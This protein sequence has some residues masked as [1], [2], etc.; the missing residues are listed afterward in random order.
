[1][2]KLFRKFICF[3]LVAVLVLPAAVFAEEP[4]VAENVQTGVTYPDVQSALNGAA[5]G[6]TVRLLADTQAE[7]VYVGSGKIL[8]LN[9]CTLTAETVSA[10]YSTTHIIDS[11]S[12]TGLLVVAAKEFALNGKNIQIPIREEA[13]V[14]FAPVA[15]KNQLTDVDENTKKYS[16]YFN[17]ASAA[18]ILDDAVKNGAELTFQVK[19]S[20]TTASG[21]IVRQPFVINSTIMEQYIAAWDRTQINLTVR[22]VKNLK[23]VEFAVEV[24]STGASG[25]SVTVS[26]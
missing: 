9:G 4:A 11:Q 20:Y 6:Q 3:A 23:N 21:L 25:S 14:R 16:F 8:D 15:V 7:T 17:M 19:V 18:T 22:G 26:N 10:S 2:H 5:K 12:S 24:V 1:M 13:G